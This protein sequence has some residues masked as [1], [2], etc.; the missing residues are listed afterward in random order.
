MN[1]KS[2]NCY[3]VCIV[4]GLGH[5]GLP[6]GLSFADVGKNVVLYDIDR[7]AIEKVSSGKMPFLE[8]GAEVI[9]K[10]VLGKKLHL[11]ADNN[12]IKNSNFVVVVI[13]TPI[14][15]HLN[16]N[17]TLFKKFFEKIIDFITDEQ[18]IILRSTVFPGT[19]EKIK[20][21]LEAK[22]KQTKLSFCPERIAQGKAIEELRYIPQ[23]VAAFDDTSLAEAKD[24][25]SSLTEDILVLTPVEAE[26]AK[27]FTNTWRYLQFSI[28]NY[29][30]QI[31][32]QNNLDFYKIYDA[33]TYNYPRAKNFPGA[34]FAAGPCLL[35]DTMQLVA[36]SN[37]SFF[38]GHAAMLVN[39]GLPNFIVQRLKE[40]YVIKTKTVGI[41]GM[42]F[43]ANNDDK[44]ESLSYKLK[45]ILEMEAKK[46][47][48]SDEYIQETNFISSKELMKDSDIIILATPHKEYVG[49]EIGQEKILVDPWN[50]Y[51][52]GGLF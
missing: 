3:D 42:A 36:Y 13:G 43:K 39:E 34:G 4:G 47:I 37:N 41:L 44:R 6:L 25:F 40:K 23:I 12:V 1:G 8:A 50:F 21:Y 11:S 15:E 16:P 30:Y 18:H 29:F 45:K 17:F 49:L 33:I 48:C 24:F 31:T 26:L 28:A 10:N 27:L 46:V 32:T 5:V 35:K 52:K 20:E 14:D 51:G 7:A 2:N 9:L 19:T 22:G 38:M